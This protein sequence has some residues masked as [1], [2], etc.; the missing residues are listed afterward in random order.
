M[1]IT[2]FLKKGDPMSIFEFLRKGDP[3][4]HWIFEAR[5]EEERPY[6]YH[7]IFE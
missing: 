6:V 4:Y 5:F 2:K 3:I 7:W 1:S